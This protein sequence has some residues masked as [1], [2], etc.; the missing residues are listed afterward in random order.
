[1]TVNRELF[2]HVMVPNYAPSSVIPVR[3]I[4]LKTCCFT[5]DKRLLLQMVLPYSVLMIKLAFVK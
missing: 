3:Q 4:I 1:M 5:K 2:D